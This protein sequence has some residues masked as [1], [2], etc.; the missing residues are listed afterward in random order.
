MKVGVLAVQGAFA[1]HIAVLRGQGVESEPVRLPEELTG[2]DGLIIP[3]GESTVIGRLMQDTSLKDRIKE[4]VEQGLAILGTCAGLILLAGGTN[5]GHPAPLGIL[6]ITVIRNAYGRQRESFTTEISMPVLG[7]TPFPAVFI[8]APAIGRVSSQVD[9]LGRLAD[10]T[11]VAVRQGRLLATS[12]H[13]ELTGDHRLHR[14]FL[15][16]ITE[17]R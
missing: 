7:E 11:A 2:L 10:G 5:N 15:N 4:M 14:Y 1:E 6:D 12:F 9:V 3:G 16:I 17:K 13:P 8:R